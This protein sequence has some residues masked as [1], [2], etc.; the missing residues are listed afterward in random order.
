MIPSLLGV[1]VCFFRVTTCHIWMGHF[2]DMF[3]IDRNG[4]RAFTSQSDFHIP[5]RLGNYNNF[6]TSILM[7]PGAFGQFSE[8]L[9]HELR[10]ES[11]QPTFHKFQHLHPHPPSQQ[12]KQNNNN[13]QKGRFPKS[14]S[15]TQTEL[16]PEKKKLKRT[17]SLPA[18]SLDVFKTPSDC[19]LRGS[20][21][22]VQPV[23]VSFCGQKTK[24]AEKK[25]SI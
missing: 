9:C 19:W 10:I 3:T 13:N 2:T 14:F 15:L 24:M 23:T 7:K 22:R 21:K 17:P 25:P 12:K 16:F 1:H 5:K 11:F 18:T 8:R 20:L 4:M 6:D